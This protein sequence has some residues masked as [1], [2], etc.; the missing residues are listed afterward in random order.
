MT[1]SNGP[2]LS[3][4]NRDAFACLG[5]L[6]WLISQVAAQPAE[7]QARTVPLGEPALSGAPIYFRCFLRVP[8]NMTS[9]A[10]VDL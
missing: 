8:D 1:P 7:W 10:E 4:V 9:R 2:R 3:C 6:L 5:L